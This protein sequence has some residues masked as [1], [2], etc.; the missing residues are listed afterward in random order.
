MKQNSI[1]EKVS[2]SGPDPQVLAAAADVLTAGGLLVF[3]TT[4]LYGLGADAL[5]PVSVE[6][7]YQV[8]QRDFSKPI[9]VLVK[10]A[11]ELG[12]IA[13]EVP[14]AASALVDAFWPGGLTII[15]EARSELPDVLTGNTGKIGVR[16]PKHPVA[17][18][19]VNAFDG[20]ITGTSA[21]LSGQAG[22][23]S[24]AGLDAELVQCVD[25][26]LD[27]GPLKGGVGSTVVDVT[28]DPPRVLREG[29]VS[30]QQ[31]ESVL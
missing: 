26:V 28:S 30:K 23:S 12:R 11:S 16:V 25:M 14:G 2:A 17:S 22:C 13:K 21:N 3:P 7:I 29:T 31:L 27:A 8:K 9:L 20:P 24:V 18:A 5:N 19:L 1:F 10:D 4:G 6:K 15:L